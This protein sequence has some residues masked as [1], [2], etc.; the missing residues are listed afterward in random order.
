MEL[1]ED[2]ILRVPKVSHVLYLKVLA[3][4]SSRGCPTCVFRGKQ[5]WW[6]LEDNNDEKSGADVEL[7]CSDGPG[8]TG[9]HCEISGWC[10]ARSSVSFGPL[11]VDTWRWNGA[12]GGL[13]R[14][15]RKMTT[16][17]K[18]TIKTRRMKKRRMILRVPFFCSTHGQ[19]RDLRLGE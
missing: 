3:S 5:V 8:C 2:G 10:N 15:R 13:Q 17:K 18:M 1:E 12:E 11:A 6:R 7:H 16:R 9:A 19:M 14:M 4:L